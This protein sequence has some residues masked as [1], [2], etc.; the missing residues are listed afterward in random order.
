MAASLKSADELLD[1]VMTGA[2]ISP[3]ERAASRPNYTHDALMDMMLAHPELNQNQLA[4]HFGYSPSWLSSIICTD[5]FQSRYAERRKALMD[6]IVAAEI[7]KG[8]Q[9]MV[10]RSQ[11][12]LMEKLN[13]P[14]SAIPDQLALR[15][16]ELS[17]RAAGYGAKGDQAPVQVNVHNHLDALAE[18]LTGLLR[19]KRAEAIEGESHE[20][21]SLE[22][23]SAT[24]PADS[25]L[26][27][28][29][30]EML[31]DA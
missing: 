4:A 3:P 28:S 20:V 31:G 12:I 18:N 2:V 5:S 19:R 30:K 24:A 14:A 10:V 23:P 1:S 25:R 7:E 27:D 6:P 11:A 16:F 15:A 17:T 22:G 8:F 21:Q 13:Q 29:A 9:V 26:S